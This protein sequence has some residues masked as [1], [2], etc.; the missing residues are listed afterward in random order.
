MIKGHFDN[1]EILQKMLLLACFFSPFYTLRLGNILFTISDFFF[2]LALIYLLI[3]KK[4]KFNKK[5]LIQYIS[6]FFGCFLIIF[7]F[8]LSIFKKTVSEKSVTVL[9]I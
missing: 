3:T 6:I 2:S 5:S 7:G 4:L 1:N 8:Y 9:L